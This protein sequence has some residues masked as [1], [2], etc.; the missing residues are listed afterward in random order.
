[1]GSLIAALLLATGAA[2]AQGSDLDRAYEEVKVARVAL[3]QARAAR[4]RGEEP[5]P[6][7]RLGIAGAPGR[8]RL[9]DEYWARQAGLAKNVEEAQRRLDAALARWNALR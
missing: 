6:G 5:L 7:E 9:S 2:F 4:E 3:E 8:T 1:M